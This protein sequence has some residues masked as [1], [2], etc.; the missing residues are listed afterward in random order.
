VN[1][2][3]IDLTRGGDRLSI[4]P[5]LG[6]IFPPPTYVGCVQRATRPD[7]IAVYVMPLNQPL[8]PM[9]IPLRAAD[10]DVI[11]NLQPLVAQAYDRGR[12][13]NLDYSRPLRPPLD[14]DD[15]VIVE[16]ILT[17]GG[18]RSS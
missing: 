4:L 3:E 9:R 10:E 15:A 16:Q 8:K 18:R 17:R 6:Q 14:H 12:Y 13:G 7:E 11:L 1:V 5:G 2:V